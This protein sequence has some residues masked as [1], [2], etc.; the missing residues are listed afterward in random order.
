MPELKGDAVDAALT[1]LFSA[2]PI[3]DNGFSAGVAARVR[4]RLWAR[5]LTVPAAALAGLTIAFKPAV[6]LLAPVIGEAG[7]LLRA[8]SSPASQVTVASLVTVTA[9][10]AMLMLVVVDD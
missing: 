6:E 3:E 7:L 5:R 1:A 2:T 8:L 9:V 4:R 10:F